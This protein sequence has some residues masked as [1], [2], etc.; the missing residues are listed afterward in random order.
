MLLAVLL[1]PSVGYA[2]AGTPL[3]WT[4]VLHLLLG[5]L[6]I[7][8]VEGLLL[9]ILFGTTRKRSLVLLVLANYLSAWL[10]W[11][12][13]LG[14]IHFCV[15]LTI[16]NFMRWLFISMLI[17]F[18]ITL[19]IEFPFFLLSFER[20]ERVI[21]R[22]VKAT[23]L[24]NTASYL[25][26][27]ALYCWTS[28]TSLVTGLDV[29]DADQMG[30]PQGYNLYYISHNGTSVM[31]SDLIGGTQVKIAEVASHYR[32]DRL[33]ARRK[34]EQ[35]YDLLILECDHAGQPQ[36]RLILA[37]FSALAPTAVRSWD[38]SEMEPGMS[39]DLGLLP[40]LNTEGNWEFRT[41]YWIRGGIEGRNKATHE[42]FFYAIETPICK[43]RIGNGVHLEGDFVVF[44]LGDDQICILHP[45]R[46]QIALVA[47]GSGP[48]VAKVK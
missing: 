3:M 24:I 5:N 45:E 26:L 47:R 35:H 11:I 33:F 28:Q 20:T 29:V 6:V 4:T 10:G 8:V 39:E 34:D 13:L 17:A 18:G 31:R 21:K 46:K 9:A 37:D 43:W 48:L 38:E 7:G 14:C 1:L 30:I 15:R 12:L 27:G 25:V 40:R 2:D 16:D 22:A 42:S 41:A 19:L 44:Q 23:F 32:N 36:K